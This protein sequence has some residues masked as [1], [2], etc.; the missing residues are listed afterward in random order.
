MAGV[1]ELPDALRIVATRA[2]L[3]VEHCSLN[4]SGMLAVNTSAT[5]MQKYID[6]NTEYGGLS[7]A[8]HN[9]AKDCVVGGPLDM[10]EALK[11]DLKQ[12][13][14]CK[15]TLLNS[16]MAYHTVA[17]E[18]VV[19]SLRELGKSVNWSPPKIPVVCNVLGRVVQAGE[20]AFGPDFPWLHCRQPVLFTQGIHDLLSSPIIQE[21]PEMT[22]LEIGPHPSILLMIKSH[23]V[24]RCGK[25]LASMRK[26]VNP[27][28]T[29]SESLGQLYLSKVPINW[30]KTFDGFAKSQCTSLPSYQFDYTDF[31]VE[32]GHEEAAATN[33]HSDE[34]TK[35][36]YTLLGRQIPAPSS[37][38]QELVFET[39]IN[40]LADFIKGHVVCNYAL[41]PA[42]IYHEMALAAAKL[43]KAPHNTVNLQQ[44][45][46]TLADVTYLNPLIYSEN[47]T[48]TVRITLGYEDEEM[49]RF[50]VESFQSSYETSATVHCEGNVK[51]ILEA[52]SNR[53][54]CRLRAEVEQKKVRFTQATA[55][56]MPQIF[57]TTAVY[58]KLFP[59]V[60][61]Y[62]SIY[63]AIKSI[64]VSDDG[65]EALANVQLPSN[66]IT[67]TSTFAANPVFM[68]VL[69]H[70]AGFI[71]NLA[72]SN[73]DACICKA[74]SSARIFDETVDLYKPFEVYCNKLDISED[75]AVIADAYAIDSEGKLFAAFKGMHFTCVKLSKI[76]AHFRHT[77]PE[78]I[79]SGTPSNISG[80]KPEV[81]VRASQPQVEV[82]DT[83]PLSSQSAKA[84]CSID[85]KMIV[86]EV[87]GIDATTVS[88]EKD[89]DA[90]GVDSLMILELESRLRDASNISFTSNDLTKC[91]T[92]ADVEALVTVDVEN[93]TTDIREAN[94]SEHSEI[95][96]PAA[97]G[98]SPQPNISASS[99]IAETCGVPQ[100]SV[101]QD[102]RLDALGIDSLM[103]LELEDRL[104]QTFSVVIDP[105]SFD[106][107]TT[108][109]DVD[110][111]I[112][113]ELSPTHKNSNETL[114]PPAAPS[115]ESSRDSSS[116]GTLTSSLTT[117]QTST[118]P[119]TENLVDASNPPRLNKSLSLVHPGNPG[120]DLDP[121]VLIHDGSGISMKYNNIKPQD[122]P[123]W[124]I[125]NP[126]LSEKEGWSSLNAMASAYA[127]AIAFKIGRS[128][129]LGGEPP[130]P[131]PYNNPH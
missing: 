59:R 56:T 100:E 71:S 64:T 70:T 34:I 102:A 106:A 115:R 57:R 53:K 13:S 39:S 30:R 101:T 92:V 97:E 26:N 91:V 122:R 126:K 79:H 9:G 38:S 87:C 46:Q 19:L 84:P 88:S 54:L 93:V 74:V 66:T 85:V 90:L 127:D 42:S 63:Q 5:E 47:S 105:K 76:E 23:D 78:R 3:F 16:P 98:D 29:L 82:S 73:D 89:L 15:A 75:N 11:N 72:V 110:R 1:L 104:A 111:L 35:T 60:V 4:T 20:E 62:S 121:L 129:I 8:C 43:F 51:S 40:I 31:L 116:S 58:E 108:V 50:A 7:I 21:S 44:P 94:V 95:A 131:F 113:S 32:Y 109:E 103:T 10:L 55:S 24:S 124:T 65:T 33:V 117:P 128:C 112:I 45:V 118:S 119:S 80:A 17:A 2:R 18:P 96:E 107:C 69:L 28:Q 52:D 14:K 41:C 27:W 81:Q 25:S 99:I 120:N 37:Q 12:Q 61:T 77:T 67:T 83:P 86:A 130:P 6:S 36:P 48:L 49:K 125:S 22:W 114:Q 68:D 123:L